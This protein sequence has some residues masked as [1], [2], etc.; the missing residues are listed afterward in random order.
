MRL[1][2][3]FEVGFHTGTRSLELEDGRGGQQRK[4]L[5][6]LGLRVDLKSARFTVLGVISV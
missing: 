2:L 1:F 5:H 3:A 4:A 6:A